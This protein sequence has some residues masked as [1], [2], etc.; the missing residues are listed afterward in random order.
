LAQPYVDLNRRISARVENLTCPYFANR[1]GSHC[2]KKESRICGA[3][4]GARPGALPRRERVE[5]RARCRRRVIG[6]EDGADD[7]DA[8]GRPRP[9]GGGGAAPP[10]E[11]PPRLA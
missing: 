2:E 6:A 10:H 3:T 9:P 11:P 7:R 1:G 5:Q 4:K 8:G